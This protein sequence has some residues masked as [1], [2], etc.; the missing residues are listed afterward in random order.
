MVA[1]RDEETAPTV[2]E[3]HRRLGRDELADL[4]GG[5]VVIWRASGGF[6]LRI[7]YRPGDGAPG[8]GMLWSFLVAWAFF[9]PVYGMPVGAGMGAILGAI[10]NSIPRGL[11][12]GL[13]RSVRPG[14]SALLVVA[15]NGS[16]EELVQELRVTGTTVVR[17]PLPPRAER[18]LREA[19]HGSAVA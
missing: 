1:Y 8:W 9:V 17:A 2:W 19:L 5:A 13:G 4:E 7:G 12:E 15:S 14:M 3:E 11:R 6:E 10:D 18:Q 16:A